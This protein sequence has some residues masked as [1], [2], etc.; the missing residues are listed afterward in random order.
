M[1]IWYKLSLASGLTPL[2]AGCIIFL[3]WLATRADWL[4]LAGVYNI[5]AGLALF[6][7]GLGFLLVYG[8]KERKLTDRY[9]VKR[10]L[11]SLGILLFNFPVAA[12]ALYSAEYIISTST[13][14]VINNSPFEITD[15]VISERE[16]SYPFPPI[17]AGQEVIEYF[18][19]KYE[20]SVNYKLS[21]NG[22]VKTGVMFGY[23][24]GGMGESATMVISSNGAVETGR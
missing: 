10:T 14:I 15:L 18:H 17:A 3:S 9:P 1:G 11:I 16:Q 23:V 5:M 22:S 8:Q 7:C 4:M 13:A 6:V 2:I 24:T 19:F 12:L 20:G 21:L